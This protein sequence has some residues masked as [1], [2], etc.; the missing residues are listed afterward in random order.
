[1]SERERD[2]KGRELLYLC[3]NAHIMNAASLERVKELIGAGA[4]LTFPGQT[5][6]MGACR[7]GQIEVVKLILT[8]Q[9]SAG[10]NAN[11]KSN[12]VWSALMNACYYGYVE[13]VKLLA[14]Q[15]IN[16]N[17]KNNQGWSALMFACRYGH[18]EVV[19]LLLAAQ[20]ISIT[21]KTNDGRAALDVVNGLADGEV[22]DSMLILFQGE[23]RFSQSKV[24]SI[25]FR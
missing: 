14:A 20:G 9:A 21:L 16:I 12:P 10:I 25:S 13:I 8:A 6:L 15:G 3:A 17:E 1:M 22:K 4:N 2:A 24:P 11:E 19:K 18:I 23:F 7:Y 5:A